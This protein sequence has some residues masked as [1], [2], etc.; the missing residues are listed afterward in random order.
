MSSSESARDGEGGRGVDWA[1][2]D[3]GAD[4]EGAVAAG[5]AAAT[6]VGVVGFDSGGAVVLGG[7]ATS[8]WGRVDDPS[9]CPHFF[10]AAIAALNLVTK[11]DQFDPL[12]A[13]D[14]TVDGSVSLLPEYA[15]IVL[16][17]VLQV[18]ATCFRFSQW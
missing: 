12:D 4:A 7:T 14:G 9:K 17:A 5:G 2:M 1:A 6:A 11:I 15:D 8:K 3:G 16:F 18:R 13:S 10:F